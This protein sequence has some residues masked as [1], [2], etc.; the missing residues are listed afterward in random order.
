MIAYI[1]KTGKDLRRPAVFLDRDGTLIHDRPGFYL[2]DPRGLKFYVFAFK[3]LRLL[4]ALGYRLIVV[5]NQAGV[6]RGYMTLARSKAI[7]MKLVKELRAEGIEP[8]GVYFCPHAPDAGCACRKPSGGLVKEALRH[9]LVDLPRSIVIGDKGSD[10]KLA[11]GLGLASVLVRTG[12]GMSELRENPGLAAGRAV[13]AD[14]LAA[15]KWIRSRRQNG[16]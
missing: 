2:T 6:G 16:T 14:L 5:T 1:R 8:D 11:D 9:H 13:K 4:A 12:H 10:M 15:A 7:N 3:A